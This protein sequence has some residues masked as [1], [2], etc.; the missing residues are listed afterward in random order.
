LAIVLSI[1][2]VAACGVFPSPSRPAAA[3]AG[4]SDAPSRDAALAGRLTQA[5]EAA[6]ADAGAP[7]AQAAVVFA[8]GSVWTGAAG[9]STADLPMKPELLMAI[10]SITKVYT[11][12]LILACD[13]ARLAHLPYGGR[14][15]GHRCACPD[16]PCTPGRPRDTR[17]T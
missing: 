11:A 15:R 9:I 12:A 16:S 5:L 7:G 8:D 10:G 4:P 17:W 1:V 2:L 14:A 6:L 13:A 3:T